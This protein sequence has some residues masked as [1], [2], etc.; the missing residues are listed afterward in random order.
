VRLSTGLLCIFLLTCIVVAS[1][2]VAPAKDVSST[3]VWL[4]P[5][6]IGGDL[7]S[8]EAVALNARGDAI[9]MWE[10]GQ[11]NTILGRYRGAASNRWSTVE[12]IGPW[13]A[14]SVDPAVAIDAAGNVAATWSSGSPEGAWASRRSAR[15]GRWSKAVRLSATEPVDRPSIVVDAAG[16]AT[17]AWVRYDGNTGTEHL[18]TAYQ[19]AAGSWTAPSDIAVGAGFSSILGSETAGNRAGVT[20]LIWLQ[21]SKVHAVMGSRGL[22]ESPVTL[23]TAAGAVAGPE[24]AVGEGGVTAIGWEDTEHG[25]AVVRAATRRPGGSWS[26]PTTLS[27]ED[28][29]AWGPLLA[30][31]GSGNVT[32]AWRTNV[33][34]ESSYLSS[35]SERWQRPEAISPPVDYAG[36]LAIAGNPGGEALLVW[37]SFG[38]YGTISAVQRA[39]GATS[40]SSPAPISGSSDVDRERDGVALDDAGDALVVWTRLDDRYRGPVEGATLDAAPPTLAASRIPRSA[41]A[42]TRLRLLASFRD[43]SVTTISWTFGDG[44]TARGARILHTYRRPGLYTVGVTA[45]DT[46]GHTT[47]MMKSVRITR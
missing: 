34:V 43:I 19:P 40:W 45:T 21:D 29:Q 20:A 18:E 8:H 10:D 47:R 37:N 6:A 17:A 3:S 2:R 13:T 41:R 46:V 30:V 39:A 26:S 16:D 31:D 11:R 5:A 1:E 25:N 7:A 44:T 35:G 42:G 27:F 15:D 33:D 4:P 14:P 32:A 9:V 12:T 28:G 23:A 36:A 22:W 38:I 24:V